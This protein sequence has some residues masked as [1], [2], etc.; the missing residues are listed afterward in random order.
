MVVKV[1]EKVHASERGNLFLRRH[2]TRFTKAKQVSGQA[3]SELDGRSTT[4]GLN[5]IDTP[6]PGECRRFSFFREERVWD[7]GKFALEHAIHSESE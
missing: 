4:F 1:F 7:K 6:A 5:L 3:G 2:Q